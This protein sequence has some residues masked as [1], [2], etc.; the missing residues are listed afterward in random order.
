MQVVDALAV[1]LVIVAGGAFWLG[2]GAL[3]RADDLRAL[4]W[5][6]VGVVALRAATQIARPGA[7]P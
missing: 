6:V 1:A 5:L 4:Y 2:E 7:R 3:S